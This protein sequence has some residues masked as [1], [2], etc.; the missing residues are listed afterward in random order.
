MLPPRSLPRPL[1]FPTILRS[2]LLLT[3][4]ARQHAADLSVSTTRTTSVIHAL[5]AALPLD[6]ILLLSALALVVWGVLPLVA[7]H[8]VSTFA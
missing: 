4:L 6:M 8:V 7:F 2:A 1:A 5:C 3:L